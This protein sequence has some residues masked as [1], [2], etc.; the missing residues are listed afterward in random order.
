[1]LGADNWSFFLIWAQTGLKYVLL[2]P[3]VPHQV[4]S[5]NGWFL[6]ELGV[7]L[8]QGRQKERVTWKNPS[9]A[10]CGGKTQKK[11]RCMGKGL[12]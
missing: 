3:Q 9:T 8:L 7:N 1:M 12:K 6:R 5:P 11:V 4:L 2:S 10:I